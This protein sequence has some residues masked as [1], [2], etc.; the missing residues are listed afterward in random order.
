[1]RII[2][3]KINK[4]TAKK[5]LIEYKEIINQTDLEQTSPVFRYS[6]YLTYFFILE[7]FGDSLYIP[8][9]THNAIPVNLKELREIYYIIYQSKYKYGTLN[10]LYR[11][12]DNIQF[13]TFV[14]AYNFYKYK[15]KVRNRSYSSP[16]TINDTHSDN[17]SRSL[18]HHHHRNRSVSP[19]LSI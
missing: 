9:H 7:L 1:V 18:S 16:S 17:S 4:K 10:S 12:M 15:K 2:F 11:I 8:V 6:L 14:V 13:Q 19:S 5:K 3:T